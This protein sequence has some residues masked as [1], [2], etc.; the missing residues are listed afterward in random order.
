MWIHIMGA[1]VPMSQSAFR[2]LLI[3]YE[4]VV[5]TCESFLRK[6]RGICTTIH[7]KHD[8]LYITNT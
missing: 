8:T 3:L 1:N 7:I 6:K 5:S 2:Y 4:A